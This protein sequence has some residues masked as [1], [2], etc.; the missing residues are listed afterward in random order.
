MKYL[1]DEAGIQQDRF[2]LSIAGP[3]EP[4]H[5]EADPLLMRRN[6][7]VEIHQLGEGVLDGW[8]APAE[9]QHRFRKQPGPVDSKSERQGSDE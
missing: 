1:V 2:R 9:R 3:N 7:R 5:L 8:G 4:F 6:S